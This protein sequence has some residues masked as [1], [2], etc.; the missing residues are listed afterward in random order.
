MTWCLA[1]L[2]QLVFPKVYRLWPDLA[3]LTHGF[4]PAWKIN[5]QIC[6]QPFSSIYVAQLSWKLKCMH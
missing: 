2:K 4:L 3:V 6:I 1:K 5:G